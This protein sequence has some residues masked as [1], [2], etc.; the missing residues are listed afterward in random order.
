M[1]QASPELRL[2]ADAHEAENIT[3]D[4]YNIKGL[5]AQDPNVEYVVDIGSNIGD[6]ALAIAKYYPNAKIILC[7][8][9]AE[10]MKYSKLNTDNKY[11][12]VQKAIVGDPKLK[13][14]KFVI[15]KWQGNHHVEGTFNWDNYIPA[16]SEK[17][18]EI[19]VEATTLNQVVLENKFPRVDLLKIDTEGAEPQILESFKLG[20]GQ[21]KHVIVEFH[22]Q[23]DLRRIKEALWNTHVMVITEGAFKEPSG[24]VANGRVE[25]TLTKGG[26]NVTTPKLVKFETHQVAQAIEHLPY[27]AIYSP[28]CNKLVAKEGDKWY[29]SNCHRL[30]VTNRP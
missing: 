22:S 8:P 15:C 12:Y 16:G 19:E 11:I 26:S 29:C 25:A 18:G 2:D 23:S 21:V 27:G 6:S 7:E 13:T 14:V 20:L 17:V 30:V 10:M 9:E 3:N 4:G 1:L 5:F 28:C 24:A